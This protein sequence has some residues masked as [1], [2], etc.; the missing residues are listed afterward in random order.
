[1]VSL[2]LTDS[3][4]DLVRIRKRLTRNAT[5]QTTI[6]DI[7]GGRYHIASFFDVFTELSLDGGVTWIP[8]ISVSPAS[9][10][11]GYI[12]LTAVPEPNFTCFLAISMAA[13]AWTRDRRG[14]KTTNCAQ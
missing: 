9:L 4:N 7:G 3:S 5:G 10:P 12:R 1:M 6:T 11:T 14:R 8:S 2:D 13:I